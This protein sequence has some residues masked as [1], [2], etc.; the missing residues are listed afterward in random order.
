M[1]NPTTFLHDILNMQW[2]SMDGSQVQRHKDE[3]I[4]AK[5]KGSWGEYSGKMVKKWI[6]KSLK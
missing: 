3:V 2:K 1:K 5:S 4:L 6:K